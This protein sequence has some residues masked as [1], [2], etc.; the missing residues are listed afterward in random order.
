MVT[1]NGELL[2]KTLWE[3][4]PSEV[5][6]F[7]ERINFPLKYLNWFWDPIWGLEIKHLKAHN[8]CDKG[9]FSSI[10]I[11]QLWQPIEF[12]LSQVCYFFCIGW[13]TP[14]EKTGLWQL[15]KM[16]SA[17]RV[18]D[19]TKFNICLFSRVPINR[20]KIENKPSI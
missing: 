16:P 14:S 4:A 10:I 13:D 8:L 11:S 18:I 12:K 9:V 15:P 2:Y 7:W 20:W 19:Q 1:S 5:L 3:T 17:L 6:S